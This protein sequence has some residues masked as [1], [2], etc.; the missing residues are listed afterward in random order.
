MAGTSSSAYRPIEA[1]ALLKGCMGWAAGSGRAHVIAMCVLLQCHRVL[2]GR[3]CGALAAC[4]SEG[5]LPARLWNLD[6]I[7]CR[8]RGNGRIVEPRSWSMI[9]NCSL[10]THTR[11]RAR[12]HTPL[13]FAVHLS[14]MGVSDC[15]MNWQYS[16]EGGGR[17]GG[18]HSMQPRTITVTPLQLKPNLQ[19]SSAWGP[20]PRSIPCHSPRGPRRRRGVPPP[21]D[22]S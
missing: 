14:L 12:M 18:G 4:C 10:G 11:A 17:G 16:T 2:R 5:G 22:G 20:H 15:N 13:S 8:D 1:P 3:S 6:L 19:I 9:R 21:T 7:V